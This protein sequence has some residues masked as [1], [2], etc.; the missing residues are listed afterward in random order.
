M[1]HHI[2]NA[3]SSYCRSIASLIHKPGKEIPVADTLS[4]KS[5]DD[6]DNSLTEDMETQ[7]HTVIRTLPVSKERPANLKTATAEDEQ[8]SALRHAIH[9]GWSETKKKCPPLISDTGTIA[10]KSKRLMA[11]CLRVKGSLFLT[12]SNSRCYSTYTQDIL[13]WKNANTG[14]VT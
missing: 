11:F 2:Y 3:C 13:G 6:E 4:R 14:Q 8:L 12:S 9:S 7:I 5:T 1:R 10:V